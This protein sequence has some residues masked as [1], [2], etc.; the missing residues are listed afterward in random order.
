METQGNHLFDRI[1]AAPSPDELARL[2]HKHHGVPRKF[3]STANGYDS[4]AARH[5]INPAQPKAAKAAGTHPHERPRPHEVTTLVHPTPV[6][7]LAAELVFDHNVV[8]GSPFSS[9][10]FAHLQD[11]VDS[12]SLYVLADLLS[13]LDQ[14][15]PH[16]LDLPNEAEQRDYLSIAAATTKYS[17]DASGALTVQ[18]TPASTAIVRDRRE[19]EVQ[20]RMRQQAVKTKSRE[21]FRALESVDFIGRVKRFSDRFRLAVS[22]EMIFSCVPYEVRAP[23]I[24]APILGYG[25]DRL[26]RVI[27]GYLRALE[28][29]S[30]TQRIPDV[31]T[32]MDNMVVTYRNGVYRCSSARQSGPEYGT[33]SLVAPSLKTPGNYS[34]RPA[35]THMVQYERQ[36]A[37][38]NER[39]RRE[40]IDRM[41]KTALVVSTEFSKETEAAFKAAQAEFNATRGQ[42][43]GDDR[44]TRI[45]NSTRE[46]AATRRQFI[47]DQARAEALDV[48]GLTTGDAMRHDPLLTA[49]EKREFRLLEDAMAVEKRFTERLRST[50]LTKS[51]TSTGASGCSGGLGGEEAGNQMD[52]LRGYHACDVPAQSMRSTHATGSAK[53]VKKKRAGDIRAQQDNERR[54]ELRAKDREIASLTRD[55]QVHKD[56]SR[57]LLMG[58]ARLEY[59][60]ASCKRENEALREASNTTDRELIKTRRH[61]DRL[62][63]QVDQMRALLERM[64]EMAN[65]NDRD[66]ERLLHAINAY[67]SKVYAAT[68][69]T[70]TPQRAEDIKREGNRLLREFVQFFETRGRFSDEGRR[71]G[72]KRVDYDRVLYC[73]HVRPLTIF[74]HTPTRTALDSCNYWLEDEWMRDRPWYSDEFH[75]DNGSADRAVTE[76]TGCHGGAYASITDTP[77]LRILNVNPR[78][79]QDGKRAVDMLETISVRARVTIDDVFHNSYLAVL[80][81]SRANIEESINKT[82]RDRWANFAKASLALSPEAFT[83]TGQKVKERIST[84]SVNRYVDPFFERYGGARGYSF[85]LADFVAGVVATDHYRPIDSSD[86]NT[87]WQELVQRYL[88]DR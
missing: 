72:R 30:E 2:L 65:V 32:A 60:L 6:S 75:V 56:E 31:S 84:Q 20:R 12:C 19:E 70:Y 86:K 78:T 1:E 77:E 71:E 3:S 76:L 50:N 7:C 8:G 59:M 28:Y 22:Y 35:M 82:L 47:R 24:L 57:A 13:R 69:A 54:A 29:V 87:R 52:T 18:S 74:T 81:P 43:P 79:Q 51:A 42:V 83:S 48:N 66:R 23:P 11:L 73:L 5:V 15:F 62:M 44:T 4:Q 36:Y 67:D 14:L 58:Q 27:D 85:R 26:S 55:V 16:E 33:Y 64:T 37:F 39:D 38:A 49:S 80:H 68:D 88:I 17:L 10:F 61:T 46:M 63:A 53:E 25:C 21:V 9:G 45:V 40:T 41:V 34:P